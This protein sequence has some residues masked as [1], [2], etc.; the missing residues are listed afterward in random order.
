M[1]KRVTVVDLIPNRRN[2]IFYIFILLLSAREKRGVKFRRPTQ[3]L[4]NSAERREQKCL[5][6][7]IKPRHSTRNAAKNSVESGVWSVL[8]LGFLSY[9]MRDTPSSWFQL[10]NRKRYIHQTITLI[11]NNKSNIKLSKQLLI[12]FVILDKKN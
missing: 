4:G 9:Y 8:T 6:G 5:N 3:C 12:R 1:H 10:N 2:G 11:I 7:A